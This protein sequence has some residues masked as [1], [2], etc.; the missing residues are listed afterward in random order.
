MRREHFQSIL[1]ILLLVLFSWKATWNAYETMV[2]NEPWVPLVE[3][4][5]QEVA[6][7]EK[8]MRLFKAVLSDDAVVGYVVEPGME[9]SIFVLA[10][11]GVAQSALAP[12]ILK[13]SLKEEIII[14][15]FDSEKSLDAFCRSHRV[16]VQAHVGPGL[17]VLKNLDYQKPDSSAGKS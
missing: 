17:A 4:H 14:T 10:D 9:A 8:R 15:N 3:A 6:A 2:L 7:R 12:R 16:Q 13:R 5:S 1:L 11:Y